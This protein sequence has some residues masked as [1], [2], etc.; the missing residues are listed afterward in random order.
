MIRADPAPL[1]VTV[2]YLGT[3]AGHASGN[4][5]GRPPMKLLAADEKAV[6]AT[7]SGVINGTTVHASY[8][9]SQHR[10]RL[11]CGAAEICVY[12]RLPVAITKTRFAPDFK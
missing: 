5:A 8:L 2:A 12:L 9:F 10:T 4:V 3:E 1:S 7:S 11:P 6:N